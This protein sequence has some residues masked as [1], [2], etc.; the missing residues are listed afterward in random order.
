M[1]R[2]V[3]PLFSTDCQLTLIS[4]ASSL[5]Q[6]SKEKVDCPTLVCLISALLL[7]GCKKISTCSVEITIE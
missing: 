4:R 6:R 2:S 1:F 3:V 7:S 5:D